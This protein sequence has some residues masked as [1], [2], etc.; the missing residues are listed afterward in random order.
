MGVSV[1]GVAG[2]TELD[3]LTKV[4]EATDLTLFQVIQ[5]NKSMSLRAWSGGIEDV[6][7]EG[8]AWDW[9]GAEVDG[10]RKWWGERRLD[11]RNLVSI[12]LPSTARS[13]SWFL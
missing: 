2:L 11:Q 7:R 5:V 13:T 10:K 9:A 6:V 12:I 3:D 4:I 1:D 8:K